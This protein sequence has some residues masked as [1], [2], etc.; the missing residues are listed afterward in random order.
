MTPS[1]GAQ[2]TTTSKAAA[3]APSAG[4]HIQPGGMP[5]NTVAKGFSQMDWMRRC[6]RENVRGVDAKANHKRVITDEELAQHNTV[7]DC[8]I[9]LRG[10]VYNLTE[11]VAYHPGGAEILE[12]SFGR[13]A[14][15]LFDRYHKYVNGAYIMREAQVGVQPGYVDDSDSD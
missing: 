11:Y 2:T 14:T 15:A 4:T 12:E 7:G 10:K 3:A 6:K 1:G 5:R 9:A 13:D 8:W